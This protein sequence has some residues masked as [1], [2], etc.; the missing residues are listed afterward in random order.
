[1]SDQISPQD[2]EK[3]R[4]FSTRT[5]RS[6]SVYSPAG[7]GKTHAIVQRILALLQRDDA[8]E[9]LK[10]LCVV[11]YTE[12]AANEMRIRTRAAALAK[13]V[14]GELLQ[15]LDSAFFGTIHAL[16]AS[17]IRQYG[18]FLGIPGRLEVVENLQSHW[19]T[20]LTTQ[21]AESVIDSAQEHLNALARHGSIFSVL[22][23]V[24]AGRLPAPQEA[25]NRPELNFNALLSYVPKQARSAKNVE[26]GCQIIQEWIE[27][28]KDISG[29]A[30]IPSYK[31]GGKSFVE[32]WNESF[33]PLR[34][35]IARTAAC[36]ANRI[37]L[38]F[39]QYRVGKGGV[40][41]DDQIQL[42]ALL[43]QHPEA[44]ER[45][46]KRKWTIILDEA[47]DTD[48]SQFDILLQLAGGSLDNP[49]DAGRFSMVGDPQQSIYGD[50][51]DL[52]LYE[53]LHGHFSQR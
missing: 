38:E 20:F 10:N 29:I 4:V 51:A 43:L 48:P 40:T 32:L 52:S 12:R 7:S 26:R 33:R 11:T 49:P 50:R 18:Y 34:I 47:Q 25:G 8:R 42:A 1:M 46:L 21:Q 24:A 53:A 27:R 15:M 6:L 28:D 23:I 44:R 2:E 37:G 3:R 9:V 30:P 13:G 45:I 19:R 16:C 41:F 36:A 35:W 14:S 17:M 31:E 5:D 22:D 39:R